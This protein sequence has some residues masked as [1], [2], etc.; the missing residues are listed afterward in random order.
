MANFLQW[1]QFKIHTKQINSFQRGGNEKK[2]DKRKKINE[3]W[4]IF[5]TLTKLFKIMMVEGK[6][7]GGGG[8]AWRQVSTEKKDSDTRWKITR[9]RQTMVWQRTN[10]SKRLEIHT[11]FIVEKTP[12]WLFIHT[13]QKDTSDKYIFSRPGLFICVHK[14]GFKKLV[15]Y[16]LQDINMYPAFVGCSW[17]CRQ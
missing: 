8:R 2:F 16:S 15:G 10:Q 13:P 1:A 17:D 6:R 3:T 7:G 14:N 12:S 4:N 11:T 5:P 9:D